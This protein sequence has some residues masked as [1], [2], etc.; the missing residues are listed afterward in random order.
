MLITLNTIL[1][2][3]LSFAFKHYVKRVSKKIITTEKYDL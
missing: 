1:T 3:S 2:E